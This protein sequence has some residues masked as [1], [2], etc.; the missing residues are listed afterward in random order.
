[1]CPCVC[2]I[3]EMSTPYRSKDFNLVHLVLSGHMFPD[4]EGNLVKL[5]GR[6]FKGSSY[7][8]DYRKIYRHV[9]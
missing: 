7:L 9:C 2:S 4:A 6:I 8:C 5:C 1:M 3:A